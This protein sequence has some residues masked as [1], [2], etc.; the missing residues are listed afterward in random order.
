MD[1]ES[2]LADLV[3]SGLSI[4]QAQT[5]L[6]FAQGQVPFSDLAITGFSQPQIQACIDV[7]ADSN[8]QVEL[9]QA[10]FWTGTQVVALLEA[11]EGQASFLATEASDIITTEAGLQL[12]IEDG[13]QLAIEAS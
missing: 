10:G 11:F 4:P 1:S 12:A 7:L 8:L 6:A 3:A 2:I 5:V 9:T 13:L